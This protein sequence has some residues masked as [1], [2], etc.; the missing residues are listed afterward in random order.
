MSPNTVTQ[1]QAVVPAP[2]SGSRTTNFPTRRQK[3]PLLSHSCLKRT[4]NTH[5]KAPSPCQAPEPSLC[6]RVPP[7]TFPKAAGEPFSPQVLSLPRDPRPR[8]GLAARPGQGPV[9]KLERVSLPAPS[10]SY[11]DQLSPSNPHCNPSCPPLWGLAQLLE[12]RGF[13]GLS[14]SISRLQPPQ[15][16]GSAG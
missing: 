2:A 9:V 8:Q 1:H 13:A 7:T 16:A 11:R 14:V 3:N 6:Q 12:S 4:S 10:A 5:K 15:A